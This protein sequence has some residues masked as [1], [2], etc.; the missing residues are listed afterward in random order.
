MYTSDDDYWWYCWWSWWLSVILTTKITFQVWQVMW[1]SGEGGWREVKFCFSILWPTQNTTYL[2]LG[3]CSS[4]AKNGSDR[5]FHWWDSSCLRR[6]RFTPS[7]Q[8]L[9]NSIMISLLSNNWEGQVGQQQPHHWCHPLLGPCLWSLAFCRTPG[10]PKAVAF[11]DWSP[12]F[13]CGTLLLKSLN[14]FDQIEL[15]KFV[16]CKGNVFETFW[17]L[18]DIT[19]SFVV[20]S[21]Q[22]AWGELVHCIDKI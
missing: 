3:G 18:C 9:S 14:L 17:L 21:E 19:L 15:S 6:V 2:D 7:R 4:H 20:R 11:N 13:C 12:H 10:N 16:N 22:L 8:S 5:G 1:K